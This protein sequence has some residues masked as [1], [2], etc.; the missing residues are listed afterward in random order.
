M[1]ISRHIDR[2]SFVTM[3]LAGLAFLLTV[4]GL[5]VAG[6]A[7]RTGTKNAATS[8]DAQYIYVTLKTGPS[9]NTDPAFR[10]QVF[11]GHMSNM[12]VLADAR[13]LVIAGPF[14]KP[15]DTTWRGLFILDV[16]TIDAA[17]ALVDTDPGITSG[18]FIADYTPI[19][20]STSFRRVLDLEREMTQNAAPA[21]PGAPPANI[22]GYIMLT[23]RNAAR[24]SDAI[25]KSPYADKVVWSC[26]FTGDRA[27]SGVF[28]LDATTT[29]EV[30][31]LL[32]DTA[33][34]P[35][36]IDAWWSTTSLLRLREVTP[37]K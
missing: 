21:A 15:T 11:E 26:S 28:V 6:C 8:N 4:A 5:T 2:G 23:A 27:N 1:L 7:Q 30:A 35:R 36:T 24:A 10:K 17:R 14:S 19:R 34:G 13:Q 3:S 31:S 29:D 20:G 25:A 32:P 33:T 18:I 9:T 16:P 22:R 12:K 37:K